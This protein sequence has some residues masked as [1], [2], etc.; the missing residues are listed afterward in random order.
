MQPTGGRP[1]MG[2]SPF[3]QPVSPPQAVN[4]LSGTNA[5]RPLL[6]NPPSPLTVSGSSV[7]ATKSGS[8]TACTT[9]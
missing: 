8:S 2:R 4:L 6:P 7:T 5:Q 1:V 9:N 3:F